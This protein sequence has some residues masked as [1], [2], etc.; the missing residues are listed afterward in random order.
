M[1]D[2][3][4]PPR[5]RAT[6]PDPARVQGDE[7]DA[8]ADDEAPAPTPDTAP[9]CDGPLLFASDVSR[10]E[11]PRNGTLSGGYFGI[12]AGVVAPKGYAADRVGLGTGFG[13]VARLGAEF[14]DQLI[15]GIGVGF[16]QFG[17]NRATSE[18]VVTCTTVDGVKTGCDGSPHLESSS[19]TTGAVSVEAGYQKRFRPSRG[20]SLS[21]G[22]LAGYMQG[23]GQMKR[24][25]D[26]QGCPSTS[27]DATATGV[28]VSP[29][30]RVTV[31]RA[32]TYAMIV[33][34]QWFVTGDLLQFTSMGVEMGAP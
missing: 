17:D 8:T 15:I 28:Y 9:G 1:N 3:P 14:W 24:G 5:E 18:L 29:F 7:D 12:D 21:I 30:F 19:I 16:F 10:C 27:V 2:D 13:G 34:T 4:A 33:R 20:V 6:V 25:V 23:F 26:C 11:T 31:G 32:G 22:G